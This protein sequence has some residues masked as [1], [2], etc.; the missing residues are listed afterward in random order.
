MENK[1]VDPALLKYSEKS[2][3]TVQTTKALHDIREAED[4]VEVLVEWAGLPDT[5][6]RTWEPIGVLFEDLPGLLQDYL[7]TAGKR[8]LKRQTL[9]QLYK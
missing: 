9:A 2:E 5:C 7:Q 1:D 8:D 3:C 6:D 4:G